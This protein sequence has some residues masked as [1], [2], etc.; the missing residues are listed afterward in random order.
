MLY[1][2][3]TA[4]EGQ[5]IHAV[6]RHARRRACGR[7][8]GGNEVIVVRPRQ[9][10][11][12]SDDVHAPRVAADQRIAAEGHGEGG[13]LGEVFRN[14]WRRAD[15]VGDV[16]RRVDVRF[17]NVGRGA[18]RVEVPADNELGAVASYNFV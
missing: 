16:G 6:E 8:N 2:V 1:E 18:G 3:I 11:A 13:C 5:G 7:G 15:R 4:V 12:G 9:R 10:R 14:A 17:G